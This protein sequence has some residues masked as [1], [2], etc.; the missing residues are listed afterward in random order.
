M[1]TQPRSVLGFRLDGRG[2]TRCSGAVVCSYPYWQ[3]RL[4]GRGWLRQDGWV[5]ST[6][7]SNKRYTPAERDDILRS[8]K[9]SPLTQKAFA[10][11]AAISRSTLQYWLRTYPPGTDHL[12][13]KPK[14][15]PKAS[16]P[17]FIALP[18]LLT[19]PQPPPVAACRL[20][21]PNGVVIELDQPVPTRHLLLLARQLLRL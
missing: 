8:F 15:I 10:A 1:Q 11:Q 21:L 18:N 17:G 2:Q 12:S 7:I 13:D 14:A 16:L 6:P 4:A 19:P 9:Q 3:P 20:L 5:K